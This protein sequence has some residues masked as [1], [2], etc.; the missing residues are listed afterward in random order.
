LPVALAWLTAASLAAAL[1]LKQGL[2]AGVAYDRSTGLFNLPG[3]WLPLLLI[4][5]IFLT[6][7]TV[8]ALTSMHADLA[9]GAGFS[10]TCAALYGAFS[11]IFLARGGRLWRLVLQGHS[12]GKNRITGMVQTLKQ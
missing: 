4:L 3:S 6:K 12:A 2:S 5:G 1:T 8:G 10:L 7:Y 9:H 11:G